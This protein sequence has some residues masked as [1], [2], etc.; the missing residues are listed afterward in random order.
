MVA[1]KETTSDE[2]PALEADKQVLEEF[3][4]IGQITAEIAKLSP[5]LFQILD[6][7]DCLP[8]PFDGSSSARH[9]SDR[10]PLE[11]SLLM[12]SVDEDQTSDQSSEMSSV[13]IL[14]LAVGNIFVRLVYHAVN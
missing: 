2:S 5:Y 11:G 4:V 9:D 3:H 6:S 14:Q 8:E 13:S 7:D 1:G 10:S 12:L